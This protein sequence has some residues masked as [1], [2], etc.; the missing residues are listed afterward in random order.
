MTEGSKQ[1]YGTLAALFVAMLL[2]SL[3][4]TVVAAVIPHLI[5][6]LSGAHMFFWV[7]SAYMIAELIAMP[8]FGKCSDLYGRRKVFLTGI[9]IFIVGSLLCGF[10]ASMTQLIVFR[11]IQG[12]GA[13]AIMPVAFTIVF[14]V[15]P[16]S[17][18]NRMQSF[19]ATVF[20]ISS[21]MGPVLGAYLA[22]ALSWRWIFYINLPLGLLAVGLLIVNY[23]EERKVIPQRMDVWG[24]LFMFA[25]VGSLLFAVE[26]YTATQSWLSLPVM[27]LFSAAIVFLGLFIRVESRHPD[28]FIP[29][30]LFRQ[31]RFAAGQAVGFLQGVVMMAVISFMPL[32]VQWAEG[33]ERTEAGMVIMPM[34]ISIV[35]GSYIG[36]K[37]TEHLNF[38]HMAILSGGVIIIGCGGLALF[39]SS[40]SHLIV[41]AMM[42]VLGLGFGLTFPL[43]FTASLH[44]AGP[45][46]VG[47]INALIPFFRSI[48]GA[49]GVAI[50][51]AVQTY[52]LDAT[53]KE[54]ASESV[55]WTQSIE[56]V[57]QSVWFVA[58][59]ALLFGW[60]LGTERLRMPPK[61]GEEGYEE[62]R[63]AMAA[64]TGSAESSG[65]A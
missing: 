35:V 23:R 26:L 62:Y 51:G 43:L 12:I 49:V 29:L 22:A 14:E 28:P 27:G 40:F 54:G 16:P 34:M 41:Y 30:G 37:L 36:G 44:G 9:S 48:G 64:Q 11:S 53:M 59:L 24:L 61:E 52:R 47:T 8:I 60:L 63:R 18:R 33:G 3:D 45:Q 6:D 32:Y 57:L 46:H 10:A 5:E 13:G 7:F 1:A 17:L 42:A 58:V 19:L 4:Q 55:A 31:I 2:A 50:L 56:L 39:I 21:V 38:R 25:G 20:G 65:H 15:F